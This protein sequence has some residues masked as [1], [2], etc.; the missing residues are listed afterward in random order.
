MS[1]EV[2]GIGSAV[3]PRRT[4]GTRR[5]GALVV[6]MA[7]GLVLAGC[8]EDR[9]EVTVG[10]ITKQETNPFWVTL[11]EVA[12]DTAEEED[13]RLLTATGRSDVDDESQVRAIQEMV[14][15][16]ATGILIAPADSEAVVPA[17]ESARRAGVAVVALDTPTE[18][19]SA[20]DALFATDNERAGELV[21]QYARARMAQQGLTPRIA[22]LDLAPGITSGELRRQGFLAGFGLAEGAAEVVGSADTEGDREKGRAVMAQLL[23][24]TPDINVVYTVNEPAAFGAVAALRE[25]GVDMADVVVVSVDGGCEAIKDGVRPGDIDATAQQYPENM[26]REGVRALAAA[27]RGGEVPSGYLDT[28]VELITG[29]PVDGVASRDVAFG[30]RNCWGG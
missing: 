30:V 20:V 14:E 17:I 19:G 15:Q 9:E 26:A 18:P 10:L 27:A 8:G 13:V 6:A 24:E 16:G 2:G 3:R 4:T 25:A 5:V 11:R 1:G 29:T 7:L 12:E 28:G 23:A 22:M 21:G